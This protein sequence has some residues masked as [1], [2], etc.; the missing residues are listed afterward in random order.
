MSNNY[1]GG[2]FK[3]KDIKLQPG[4]LLTKDV[5]IDVT[6]QPIHIFGV[7]PEDHEVRVFRVYNG[8]NECLNDLPEVP[9]MCQDGTSQLALFNILDPTSANGRNIQDDIWLFYQGRYRLEYVHPTVGATEIPDDVYVWCMPDTLVS[10][11]GINLPLC[12][13]NSCPPENFCVGGP[14]RDIQI[15]DVV[16]ICDNG[17]PIKVRYINPDTT[18]NTTSSDGTVVLTVTSNPN[19]SST[20]DISVP[21]PVVDGNIDFTVQPDLSLLSNE[22]VWVCD[23]NSPNGRARRFISVPQTPNTQV[24]SNDDT[25]TVLETTL[26]NGAPNFDLSVPCPVENGTVVFDRAAGTNDYTSAESLWVCDDTQPNGRSRKF[27]SFTSPEICEQLNE[28][29]STDVAVGSDTVDVLYI[30]PNTGVCTRGP[31]APSDPCDAVVEQNTPAT[32]SLDCVLGEFVRRPIPPLASN[33]ITEGEGI[34]VEVNNTDPNNTIF[35]IV[36][37]LCELT[38]LTQAQVDAATSVRYAAC[39]DGD[40]RLVPL[41]TICDLLNTITDTNV[42][43]DPTTVD[44]VYVDPTTGACTRGPI[45]APD[46]CEQLNTITDTNVEADQTTVDVIYVNPNTGLCFR[47]PLQCCPAAIAGSSAVG[48]AACVSITPASGGLRNTV[49]LQGRD[50]SIIN[51]TAPIGVTGGPGTVTISD[52]NPFPNQDAIARVT[53]NGLSMVRSL[54]PGIP[55]NVFDE[56]DMTAIFTLQPALGGVAIPGGFD[57]QLKTSW[58]KFNEGYSGNESPSTGPATGA[59][60]N[61]LFSKFATAPMMQ[62]DILVPA[63]GNFTRFGQWWIVVDLNGV[64]GGI[65]APLF[66]HAEMAASILWFRA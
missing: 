30:D 33:A 52:A 42:Q 56:I 54:A 38:E 50:L 51:G 32:H 15:G 22:P 59:G 66:F 45:Q 21:C 16:Q 4:D 35:Q 5:F 55:E 9:V 23:Q 1:K 7:L 40:N 29:T 6:D 3:G 18:N 34:D 43:V 27:L 11:M 65:P 13:E 8:E 41:P 63:G 26:A 47:G 58:V 12:G 17:E 25:V 39:V 62:E 46:I 61:D 53:M 48:G 19:G 31:I 37:D 2:K 49:I 24:T 14:D 44:F 64:V 20:F 57:T 60:A 36:L 10:T 28:V